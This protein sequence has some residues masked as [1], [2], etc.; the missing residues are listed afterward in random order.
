VRPLWLARLWLTVGWGLIVSVVTL[1]LMPKPPI[2]QVLGSDKLAH[3]LA[4]L[5]LMNWFVLLY[6]RSAEMRLALLFIGMGVTL[7][8]LQGLTPERSFELADMLADGTG[9]MLGWLLARAV[10][11]DW[12][13][14]IDR[15]LAR[16][17]GMELH[18]E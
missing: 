18:D 8:L 4:Y 16:A 10:D 6:A 14:K 12:L 11:G 13:V 2:S 7:E 17:A 15:G 1:S 3:G 5:V 9:V